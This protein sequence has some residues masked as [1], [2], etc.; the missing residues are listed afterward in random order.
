MGETHKRGFS[1]TRLQKRSGVGLRSSN[2]AGDSHTDHRVVAG[3][4]Q[5]HH[6]DVSRDGGRT[7]EL[8]IA[9]HTA[10]GVGQ[11]VGSG[12]C[13][14]VVRV[15]GTAR[16]AAGSNGEVLLAI[17]DS[18]LLVGT[19]NQV[20]ETGG[21]GGVTGDGNLNTLSLHD[22]NAFQNVVGAV[23][24]NSSALAV[25]VRDGLDQG[26]LDDAVLDVQAQLAGALLGCAPTYT[27]GVAA[28]VLNFLGL[29]P[30]TLFG[31]G[32]GTVLG[33]FCDRAH[34]IDLCGVFDH[35]FL[36]FAFVRLFTAIF[37]IK[38]AGSIFKMLVYPNLLFFGEFRR[39][40]KP[41]SERGGESWFCKGYFTFN[42][43]GSPM[44]N[45]KCE[46]YGNTA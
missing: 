20:L 43:G 45:G 27:V 4:D 14:H 1:H 9:V 29:D 12:A 8:S 2:S 33:P 35:N 19:G 6:L 37:I 7:S 11:A 28:D 39:K 44:A 30:L 26:F 46:I 15:Q 23:A 38:G 5:T 21:V 13:C 40:T 17:L 25:R 22:S 41:A 3:A 24:L 32:G 36:S 16:A 34:V 10:H 31:D 42:I 18:P